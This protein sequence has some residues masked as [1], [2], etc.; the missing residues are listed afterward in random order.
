M[1]G[2]ITFILIE[3][4]QSLSITNLNKTTMEGVQERNIL[5]Y[6]SWRDLNY[7]KAILNFL[8]PRKDVLLGFPGLFLLLTAE[9]DRGSEETST[10]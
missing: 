8:T 6:Y 10:S 7:P 3:S 9:E 5:E 1:E 4:D 2:F